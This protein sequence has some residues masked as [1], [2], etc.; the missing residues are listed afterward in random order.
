MITGIEIKNYSSIKKASIALEKAKYKYKEEYV[1]NDRI[2]NPVAVFG[3]NGSGKSSFLSSMRDLVSLLISEVDKLNP[4]IPNLS[5]GSASKTVSSIQVE[6]ELDKQS[7]VYYIST[8]FKGISYEKLVKGRKKLFERTE[9]NVTYR[10]ERIEIESPFFPA[11]RFLANRYVEDSEIARIYE[12]LSNIGYVG[13]E[14]KL[15]LVK[16]M[17]NISEHDVLVNRSN[18]VRKIL[19]EYGDFP[20]YDIVSKTEKTGKKT[21]S[22]NIMKENDFFTIPYDLMSSGMRNQSFL[23]SVLLSL[24]KDGVLVVDELE[25][26]LHP[27]TIMNFINFAVKRGVQLVFS[28]HNTSIL[29]HLRPDNIIFAHWSNGE[30][31]YKRLSDI[32]PNIRLV[33]NIEKM[34]LSATFD[35]EIKKQI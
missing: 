10:G 4:F 19:E 7:F 11:L 12:F 35:D 33:N 20:I 30:S 22:V 34:Y 25:D 14:S 26:A 23:L 32:Y 6:M 31:S 24:P 1:L 29:S 16:G 5:D 15:Y 13:A 3:S 18:E 9:K 27:F 2:A 28:S 8:S 21:Y 17:E